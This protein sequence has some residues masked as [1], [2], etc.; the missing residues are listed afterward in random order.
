M[1]LC[2]RVPLAPTAWRVKPSREG[3]GLL[4]LGYGFGGKDASPAAWNRPSWLIGQVVM[5]GSGHIARAA[6]AV[7]E[8][9]SGFLGRRAESWLFLET[10]LVWRRRAGTRSSRGVSMPGSAG[11]LELLPERDMLWRGRLVPIAVVMLSNSPLLGA[12]I[13]M[14]AVD[15]RLGSLCGSSE[16]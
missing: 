15:L 2:C 5:E 16:S 14:I 6:A 1:T 10:P 4:V 3:G 7:G 8:T 12:I 13:G 11:L 9:N